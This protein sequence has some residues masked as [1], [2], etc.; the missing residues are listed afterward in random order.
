[1]Y[2]LILCYF[3]SLWSWS[4]LEVRRKPWVICCLAREAGGGCCYRQL[5]E[6][7]ALSPICFP[8]SLRCDIRRWW[9]QLQGDIC[10]NDV[11]KYTLLGSSIE[12]TCFSFPL[13]GQTAFQL[14]DFSLWDGTV[15]TENLKLSVRHG[16]LNLPAVFVQEEKARWEVKAQPRECYSQKTAFALKVNTSLAR[17]DR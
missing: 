14:L 9:L 10:S 16:I 12:S 11:H 13:W 15:P 4:A 7:Q 3:F 5:K 1:M 8:V 6:N 17:L 2:F